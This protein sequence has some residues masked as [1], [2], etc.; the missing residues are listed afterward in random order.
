M[1]DNLDPVPTEYQRMKAEIERLLADNHKLMLWNEQLQADLD[2]AR[3][4]LEPKP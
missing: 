1:T 2:E 4:A 3:R